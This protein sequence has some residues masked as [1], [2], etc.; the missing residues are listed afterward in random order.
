MTIKTKIVFFLDISYFDKDST[1]LK[2]V[3]NFL[4]LRKSN[5]ATND[6]LIAIMD[7]PSFPTSKTPSKDFG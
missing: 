6:K 2:D 4:Y 7:G 5:M 1:S 3:L